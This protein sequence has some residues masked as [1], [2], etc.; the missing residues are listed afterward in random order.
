MQKILVDVT[1]A[2]Q[3]ETAIG[4]NVRHYF[5]SLGKEKQNENKYF[6]LIDEN[7]H[8]LFI[9]T[10]LQDLTSRIFEV[11]VVPSGEKSKS[12]DTYKWIIDELSK[13]EMLRRSNLILVGGGVVMD[14]GGFVGATYMRGVPTI[15]IPTTLVAQIDAAI[16]GKVAVNHKTAKN[17]VGAF[18]NPKMVLVD[19]QFLTTL[20]KNQIRDGLAEIIKIA[21]VY[22][23]ELFDILEKK[24]IDIFSLEQHIIQKILLLSIQSK[25]DLLK[26]DPL[27][28]NLERV[29]NFGHTLAHPIETI[30]KHEDISHGHAVAIGI[31]VATRFASAKGFCSK[32]TSNRVLR[33]LD[34]AGLPTTLSGFDYQELYK[35]IQMVVRVRNGNINLV[36]PNEIGRPLIIKDASI[37][38]LLTH[39]V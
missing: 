38:E 23:P 21:I 5:K 9:D 17:L 27:E 34:N 22:S 15:N 7:V 33:V 12:L 35:A 25:I 28:N 32:E 19:P 39:I 20:N 3:Y 6:I 26:S 24:I 16:G 30:N 10:L 18:Y 31:A 13:K 4:F 29:L 14:L 2:D 1:R 36:V 11:I 8:R 37:E